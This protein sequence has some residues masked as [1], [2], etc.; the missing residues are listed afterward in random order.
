ML[1]SSFL[2]P[3][4]A[5][6]TTTSP[7]NA[8]QRSMHG[9]SA[10]SRSEHNLIMLAF[11]QDVKFLTGVHSKHDSSPAAILTEFARKEGSS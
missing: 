6:T 7:G 4:A 3:S 9:M 8:R 1:I 11:F 10:S 5:R 2:L